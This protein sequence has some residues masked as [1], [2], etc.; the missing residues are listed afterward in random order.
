MNALLAALEPFLGLA[1]PWAYLLALSAARVGGVMLALPQLVGNRVPGQVRALVVIALASSLVWV[2]PPGETPTPSP[3]VGLLFAVQ[4]GF[5]LLLG[6][7]MGFVVHVALSTARIAGVLCGVE[8]GLSFGAVVDPLS[9]DETTAISAL[10]GH[11]SVQL[12]LALGLDRSVIAA[13]AESVR[14]Q[15]L[16][17]ARLSGATAFD[18]V[19]LGD[20]MYR[21]GVKLAL[22]VLGGV[23]ILKLAIALLTRVAQKLQIFTIAFSL[24]ILTGLII[25]RAAVPSLGAAVASELK[26][27]MHDVWR[28]ATAS[29]PPNP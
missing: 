7:G 16:G 26:S 6:L 9:N 28:T 21:T 4:A 10:F 15:P 17:T 14:T 2:S 3:S 12:F 24:S 13:L 23:F 18:L 29:P 1:W 20:P 5:E 11:M 8:M 27:S 22:P 19:A 25:L